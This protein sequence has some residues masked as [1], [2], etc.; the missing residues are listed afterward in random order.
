MMRDR[1]PPET[2]ERHLNFAG[3]KSWKSCFE[4]P[5]VS[6]ATF[7]LEIYA[8]FFFKK[9]PYISHSPK[10]QWLIRLFNDLIPSIHLSFWWDGEMRRLFSTSRRCLIWYERLHCLPSWRLL[11][12]CGKSGRSLL[13]IRSVEKLGRI[14]CFFSP[15]NRPE[16][17][18]GSFPGGWL[19]EMMI[20]LEEQILFKQV[21]GKTHH[22]I[23]PHNFAGLEFSY[24]KRLC[25]QLCLGKRENQESNKTLFDNQN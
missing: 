1:N 18:D 11:A 16:V 17:G 15:E 19:L 22:L 20:Q 12:L 5:R 7:L 2:S 13:G 9:P 25:R 8:L 4:I 21:G 3:K 10:I 14:F 24:G 23:L 6:I